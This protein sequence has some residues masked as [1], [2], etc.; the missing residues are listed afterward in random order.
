MPIPR[1]VDDTG[2]PYQLYLGCPKCGWTVEKCNLTRK[3]D[4]CRNCG[5]KPLITRR[6]DYPDKKQTEVS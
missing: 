6:S 2:M 1:F 4:T 5:Y 3:W